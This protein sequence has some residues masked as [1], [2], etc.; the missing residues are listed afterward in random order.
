MEAIKG[1]M[2]AI[3][4]IAAISDFTVA[5][6]FSPHRLGSKEVARGSRRRENDFA[7]L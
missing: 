1:N 6:V 3:R 7:L 4:D 5:V 2:E